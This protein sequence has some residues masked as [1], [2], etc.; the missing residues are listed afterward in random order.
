MLFAGVAQGALGFGFPAIST[1]VVM[2]MVDV[3]TAI[4]L[5]LLPNFAVNLISILRGGNY[6][7]SIGR[8]WPVAA[9]ALVGAFLG[10]CFLIVAPQEPVRILLALAII[11]YLNQ[12]RLAHLDWSW[13]ARRRRLSAMIFGVA[14][15]FFSGTVNQSLPPL[16]IYFTLLG[17]ET[18]VMTQILNLC[19]I[20][21]KTVQAATLA[22]AGQIRLHDVLANVPLTV[23]SIFG[24][25]LGVRVQRRVSPDVYKRVLRY[26]LFVLAI[27]LLWQ[28]SSWLLPSAHA[29]TA[30]EAEEAQKQW[31]H[32]PYGPMMTR[33]LPPSV[34]PDDLPDA[35]SP[36]ARVMARYCVQ[37]HYL[38]NPRMHTRERWTSVVDRMVW[39][40][41][42]NG[43]MGAVMKDMMARVKAPSAD[44]VRTLKRYLDAN[45]QKP[46]DSGHPALKTPAGEMF[47]IA[48]SQCH[49]AP[50]PQR[51]TAR[52]WPA[53]V[54][55]MKRHMAWANTVTG[56]PELR[57]TPVLDT[58]A[59]VRMLQQYARR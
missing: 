39:R 29:A 1:P 37:C 55:R 26:I 35:S 24:L 44:E 42:G 58:A 13:L 10:A 49:A 43:N 53:V 34:E 56:A 30:T 27:A 50:D 45:A 19:F 14:G 12:H 40:M 2:L 32:S 20:G 31:A 4:I 21:G 59:I 9:W 46:I 22:G 23:I 18:V 52:E 48:C 8:Y 51:H 38:P 7:A 3:K 11:A 36:G 5:N 6:R 17:L 16:L 47:S 54:E 41:R 15:G 25:W 57:T 33:I 28:G